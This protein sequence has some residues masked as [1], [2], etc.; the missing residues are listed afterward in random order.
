MPLT[1]AQRT[2]RASI[3]AHV[4]HSQSDSRESTRAAR[5]TFLA[6]FED[7]VDPDRLLPEAERLRRAM[8]ARAAYFKR[9]AFASAKARKKAA[10]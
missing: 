9:L 4:K 3:A 7:E 1:P 2:L 5:E 6:H 10:L 8:H